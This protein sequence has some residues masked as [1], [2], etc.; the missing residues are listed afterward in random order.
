MMVK[1]EIASMRRRRGKW[2]CETLRQKDF[3]L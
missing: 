2:L 1:K 3:N